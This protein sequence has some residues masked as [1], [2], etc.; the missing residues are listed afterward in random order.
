MKTN[1]INR[2]NR[3]LLA[4]TLILLLLPGG[5]SQAGGPSFKELNKIKLPFTP[6]THWYTHTDDFKFFLCSTKS[7]MLMLDGISGKILWQTNFKK[8]YKNEKFSNQF[9]NKQANVVLLYDEDTKKGIAMKYFI[10]GKSGKILWSSDKYV[11][12]FGQYELSDGFSNYY[13]AGTNSVLLPTKETVDLV[14]VN[15]GKIRWS[16]AITLSGKEKEFDCFIMQY[17]DLVKIITGKESEIYLTTTEGKEIKDIEPYFNKKKYL[18]DRRHAFII[19]IPEKNMY[20]LMQGETNKFVNSLSGGSIPRYKLNF[21]AYNSKTDELLWNKQYTLLFDC[22]LITLEPFIRMFYDQGMLFVEHDHFMTPDKGLTV[23]DPVNGEIMWEAQ[24][25]TCE[26]KT[27]GINKNYFTPFPAPHPLTKSGKTYVVNKTKNIVS[28]YDAA[29]GTKI[30]DSEKFPD[31]QKIPALFATDKLVIMWHG[32]DAVKAVSIVKSSGPNEYRSEYNNK[33]KYGIIAY[34]AATGKEVWSSEIISK[35]AKDKFDYIAGTEMIDGKLYC[36]TD[37]NFFILDPATGDILNSIP[38]AKAKVGDAWKMVY[39]GKEHKI[40]INCDQ[41][42]VKINPADVKMDGVVETPTIP[43]LLPFNEMNADDYYQDYAVVTSGNAETWK[44]KEF[45]C[46]D[47]DNMKVRGLDEGDL[48]FY[49]PSHFS[50]GAEMFYKVDDS[51][52]RF[53]S[54]K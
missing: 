6:S 49:D 36:A 33:D 3:I 30:W 19:D 50:Q 47:L 39:F 45:A 35:K 22:N 5:K 37:K 54:V 13:D 24:F 11:S 42:I 41:G 17:H 34:D 7:D 9:W 1:L 32:G 28:C 12:D 31:A 25:R 53:F 27:S 20:V 16:K 21:R 8:D 48:L 14:D 29:K 18:S 26:A 51:E 46:I 10:D 2:I 23:L 44:L 38:L 4:A 40:V 43:F 52:I 15:T